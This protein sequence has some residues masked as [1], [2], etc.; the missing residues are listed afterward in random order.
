MAK[1]VSQI[2]EL[3]AEIVINCEPTYTP[4]RGRFWGTDRIF[5]CNRNYPEI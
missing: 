1:L 2:E 3:Y 5:R 4:D